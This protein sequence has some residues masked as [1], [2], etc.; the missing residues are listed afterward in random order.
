MQDCMH[1]QSSLCIQ[2]AYSLKHLYRLCHQHGRILN[3]VRF[4]RFTGVLRWTEPLAT[5]VA[6]AE[7]HSISHETMKQLCEVKSRWYDNVRIKIIPSTLPPSNISPQIPVITYAHTYSQNKKKD[8]Q[9]ICVTLSTKKPVQ[10]GTSSFRQSNDEHVA[11]TGYQNFNATFHKI[12]CHTKRRI[13]LASLNLYFVQVK[14][15][16]PLMSR[17]A[18]T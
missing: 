13:N 2:A 5:V 15:V 1:K 3:T 6:Q 4:T 9:H 18:Y 10:D 16:S 12:A 8:A 17:I 11:S 14:Q 7:M